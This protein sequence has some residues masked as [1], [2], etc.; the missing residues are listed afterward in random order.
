MSLTKEYNAIFYRQP[1]N[2]NYIMANLVVGVSDLIEWVSVPRKTIKE[3]NR[4][5]FQRALDEL[6]VEKLKTHY[7]ECITPNSIL[8]TLS[9]GVVSNIDEIEDKVKDTN[10][11]ISGILKL[12][13]ESLETLDTKSKI[14][15][16]IS[17]LKERLGKESIEGVVIDEDVT[18]DDIETNGIDIDDIKSHLNE[19][20]RKLEVLLDK[21]ENDNEIDE[22]EE[23]EIVEFC[24]SYLKPAL[25]VDGQHR[26]YGAFEKIMEMW[27]TNT[28]YE[29]LLSVSSIINCD[30]KES[31]FQ[32]VIIN[33]TAQKIE[34]KFL[35]SIISTSLTN[36]ELQG[37]KQQ[38]ENS[39]AHVGQ[40]V[41][42]NN[43][44]S[45][46]IYING[47]NI[48]PFYNNIEFGIP[49]ESGILLKYNTVKGLMNKLIKFSS[50]TSTTSFGNPYS[51]LKNL[52]Q[53]EM[54]ISVDSWYEDEYW[55]QF[56]IYFWYLV[57][58]QFTSDKKLKYLDYKEDI[59]G[60]TN[61]SL[62][63]SMNYIQDCFVDSIV[64]NYELYKAVG[65]NI[66]I[67]NKKIDFESFKEVF[68]LWVKSHNSKDFK[69]FECSWKGL[70][71]YKRE[72]DKYE[73]IHNAFESQN[74]M[75]TKLFKG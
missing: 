12:N 16:V 71:S 48:N 35:S 20:L 45:K 59:P 74:F 31:V 67:I 25:L 58:N 62:K 24:D 50:A 69:F 56:I 4:I 68:D 14:Q 65:K 28:E 8:I 17:K 44:S 1:G 9:D 54:G 61:L 36:E 63:V 34:D 21:L 60:S 10:K 2:P 72:T 11:P 52:I 15:M 53:S 39:G 75:R 46:E 19:I 6:R 51:N 40:A 30:W 32:F 23:Q 66:K 42:M 43:L 29:I 70:S 3:G 47:K 38:F 33:Q 64:K 13:M 5:L 55:L 49:N 18:D 41:A 73:G 26:V 27:K 22:D 37:F 7:N 57:E